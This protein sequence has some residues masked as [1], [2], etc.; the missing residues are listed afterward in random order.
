[1]Y[2][3]SS[4]SL[5]GPLFATVTVGATF[6]HVAVLLTQSLVAL[7]ASVTFKLTVY[8]PGSSNVFVHVLAVHDGTSVNDFNALH[9]QLFHE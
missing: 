9:A 4:F 1:M 8:V 3:I 6:F 2:V 5:F 7:F